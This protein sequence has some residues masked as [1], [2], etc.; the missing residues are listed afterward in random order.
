MNLTLT[1]F[2]PLL[3]TLVAAF[4]VAWEIT[5]RCMKSSEILREAKTRLAW[6]H[7]EH[8]SFGK[9][10]YICHAVADV[11]VESWSRQVRGKGQAI[12]EVIHHQLDG[13]NS[14]GE[15][16]SLQGYHGLSFHDKQTVR[17][18][19]LDELIAYY[20]SKGD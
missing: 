8:V 11:E 10:Q 17:H 2:I 7:C 3:L 14:V 6:T 1:F 9:R 19:W 18:Q 20:E 12:R 16:L 13:V 4:T 15:W 5:R